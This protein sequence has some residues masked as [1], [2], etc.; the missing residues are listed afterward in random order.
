MAAVSN[1]APQFKPFPLELIPSPACNYIA[2]KAVSIGCEPGSIALP[3]L[4]ALAGAIGNSYHVEVKRG[5]WFEP[6]IIWSAIIAPSG[7]NKSACVSAGTRFVAERDDALITEFVYANDTYEREH[8][9]W[10]CDNKGKQNKAD[11]PVKPIAKRLQVGD[12]TLE[13]LIDILTHNPR[14]VLACYDELSQLLRSFG[15]YKS[16]GGADVASWLSMH[17]AERITVD[18]KNNGGVRYIPKAAV[19]ICGGIQPGILKDCLSGENTENGLAARFLF[20]RPPESPKKWSDRV[21]DVLLENH[22]R[23]TFNYL[24]SLNYDG[25]PGALGLSQDAQRLFREFADAHNEE[26]FATDGPLKSAYAKLE[27]YCARFAG[28]F[29][30]LHAFNINSRPELLI[31]AETL[32]SAI[33]LTEWFRYETERVYQGLCTEEN[34]VSELVHLIVTRF[35]GQVTARQLAHSKKKYR[36]SGASA[37]ALDLLQK[38]RAGHWEDIQTGGRPA[39]VFV[40]DPEIIRETSY[41]THLGNGTL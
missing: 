28:L 14:G 39:S 11:P 40:I 41:L 19:S 23:A 9:Q 16:R 2:D 37:A 21:V 1:I 4:S 36:A 32:E 35:N 15:Q 25:H 20:I 31:Q 30:L 12:I 18:R 26:L 8:T 3:M 33:R 7:S 24:I 17:R 34:E 27:A 5:E 13:A 6:I 22:I 10:T 29:H 38:S